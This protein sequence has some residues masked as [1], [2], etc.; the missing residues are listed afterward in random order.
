MVVL[1]EVSPISTQDLWSSAKVN[2][3]FLLTSL[4]KALL[5]LLLSLAERP[6]LGRVLVVPN[7]LHLRIMEATVVLVTFN[8]AEMFFVA[9]PRCVPR[10][11]SVSELCRQFLQPLGFCSDMHC[12]L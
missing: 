8:T 1:L 3:R 11:N 12:R 6:A 9:F 7:F 5:R 2:I 10:H 4:T